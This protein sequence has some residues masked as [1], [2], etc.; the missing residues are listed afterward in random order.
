MTQE[1]FKKRIEEEHLK[2]ISFDL[3]YDVLYENPHIMGCV[4]VDGK[5]KIYQTMEQYGG[6]YFIN[7][8]DTEDAAYNDLYKLVK[9]TIRAE[10]L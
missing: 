10:N 3:V 4:K 6:S 2:M 7:E 8:Y 5:W 1:E 9:L